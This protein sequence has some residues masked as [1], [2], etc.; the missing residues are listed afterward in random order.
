MLLFAVFISELDTL[1]KRKRIPVDSKKLPT[2]M[3]FLSANLSASLESNLVGYIKFFLCN[4]GA[5]P[6]LICISSR[7]SFG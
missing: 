2:R 3:S 1:F 7:I 6:F 4:Y 5:W